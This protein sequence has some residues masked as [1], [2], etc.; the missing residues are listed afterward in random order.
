MDNAAIAAP[1]STTEEFCR[2]EI[3]LLTLSSPREKFWGMLLSLSVIGVAMR[4][5]PL[6]SFED[7][8]RQI[9]ADEPTDLTT[10]FFPLHRVERMALD[11][12][13]GE[14]PSL[15]EQFAS[16]TGKPANTILKSPGARP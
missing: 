14:M 3:V 8:L 16:R 12:P 5:I 1:R 9:R 13:S 6:E 10:T 4:G 7:L 11:L 15:A 2:G